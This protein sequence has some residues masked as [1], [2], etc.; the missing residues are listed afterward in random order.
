VKL[1][2]IAIHDFSGHPFQV[3]LAR[4]LAAR[5]NQVVHLHAASF[6]TPKGRLSTDADDP[7]SL[8][9]AGLDLGEPF[10]KYS[11]LRRVRQERRYGHIL[12]ERLAGFDP[13]VVISA[14]TPLESQSVL[15][16]WS[17][18]RTRMIFWIQDVYSEAIRRMLARRA[19]I[20]GW[21]VARRFEHLEARLAREADGVVA[22][23]EDFLPTLGRWGVPQRQVS[24]VENW[25]PLA[26]IPIRARDNSWA[27]EHG[28]TGRPVLLYAGTLGLKHDPSL[29]VGLAR[30]L[31]GCDVVVVSEGLGAD[32]IRDHGVGV[33]NLRVLPF[34]PFASLPDVLA[35][36]DILLVILEAEAGTFSVPSKV[37]SSLAAGRPIVAA[38]PRSNLAARTIERAGAGVIVNPGDSQA[39]VAAAA[40][41]VGD[42][43][44]RARMGGAGR[45]YAEATFDIRCIA[46]QFEGII[47]R[48]VASPGP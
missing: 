38:V 20:L 25:A 39:F 8:E 48:A 40:R 16:G 9:I 47:E 44:A 41:L 1:L 5:G 13:D 45:A 3:E 12:V 32:W 33:E 26:D 2:R 34:Q 29:I 36:A 6:Q 19:P 23:T 43:S 14:N 10:L 30:A 35:T 31:P 21:P 27:R 15:Q 37:L 22:I 17:R 11:F 42:E 4:E 7:Q 18:G 24:V 46:T 28:L